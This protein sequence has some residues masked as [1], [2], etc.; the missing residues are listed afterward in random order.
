MSTFQEPVRTYSFSDG[1][2]IELGLEKI[3]FAERDVTELAT[4][5]VDSTWVDDLNDRILAFG[6]MPDDDLELAEQVEATEEKD[7]DADVLRDKLK[8]LRSA[9][10]RAFGEKSSKFKRFKLKELDDMRD[11][12]LLKAALVAHGV[13]ASFI[14]ELTVKGYNAAANTALQT[15]IDDYVGGLQNQ[16]MEIG[17]RDSAQEARVVEGNAIYDLLEHELCEAAKSYWRTRSAARLNDY[18]IH[19]NESGFGAPASVTHLEVVDSAVV[20]IVDDVPPAAPGDI[21]L[22]NTGP[23]GCV[24]HIYF[25]PN[26]AQLFLG[27]GITLNSGQHVNATAADIGPIQSFLLVNNSSGVNGGLDFAPLD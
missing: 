4:V 3:A 11:G 16:V 13:A 10:K 9:A 8:E 1:R 2:L 24:L 19:N 20:T 6:A 15:L 18:F 7:T 5:G 14:T 27:V 23:A 25:A 21:Y 22:K 17:S 26:P 12:D